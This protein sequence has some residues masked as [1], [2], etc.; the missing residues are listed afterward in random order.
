MMAS[1]RADASTS[2]PRTA[3]KLIAAYGSNVL[4]VASVATCTSSISE[5]AASSSPARNSTWACWVRASGSSLSAPASRVSWT[6]RLESISERS[7]SH[8][9][10]ATVNANDSPRKSTSADGSR[11]KALS[12]RR[13][14]GDPAEGPALK[15]AARP[16]RRRSGALGECAGGGAA[17]AARAT[18][19]I[20]PSGLARRHAKSAA[21][22]ASR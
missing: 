8:M 3:A 1:M 17:L 22:I 21:I 13:R 10:I 15:C 9:F 5:A 16:S 4:P 12:A 19:C 18:S 20:S 11:S 6:Y 7:A 2:L 14:M